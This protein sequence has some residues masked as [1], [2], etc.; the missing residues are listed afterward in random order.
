MPAALRER[1]WLG[2]APAA[3]E[4]SAAWCERILA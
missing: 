3:V 4:V 1:S 2:K